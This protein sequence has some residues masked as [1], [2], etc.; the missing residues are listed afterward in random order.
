MKKI[1]RILESDDFLNLSV[2][3]RVLYLYMRAIADIEEDDYITN[4]YGLAD[5]MRVSR[6]CVNTLI[7][8]GF[9]DEMKHG[10]KVKY[11]LE[12]ED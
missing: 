1:V 2:E 3:S 7:N 4:P 8:C 10:I 9:I 6:D 11:V 5:I 12:Y